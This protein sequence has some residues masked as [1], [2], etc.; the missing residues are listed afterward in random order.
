MQNF[1]TV[2]HYFIQQSFLYWRRGGLRPPASVHPSSQPRHCEEGY[3][4]RGNLL[5]NLT[6]RATRRNR[7]AVFPSFLSLRASAHTG[8]AIRP[9]HYA[10]LFESDPPE[11][12]IRTPAPYYNSLP[13]KRKTFLWVTRRRFVCIFALGEDYCVA[14]VQPAASKAP[15]EPCI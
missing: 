9:L 4:R 8:V 13:Q 14:A 15:P 1:A 11:V 10:A 3:A 7:H 2:P 12:F 5:F 6:L